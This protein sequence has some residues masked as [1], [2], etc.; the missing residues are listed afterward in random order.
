VAASSMVATTVIAGT[1][2]R[3][4]PSR[5]RRAD[6]STTAEADQKTGTDESRP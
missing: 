1:I 6:H 2:T 3:A 4:C 5:R